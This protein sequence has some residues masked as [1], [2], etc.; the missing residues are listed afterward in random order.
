MKRGGKIKQTTSDRVF[1]V[2]GWTY[3]FSRIATILL[4]VGLITHYFFYSVMIVRGRSME[5][6]YVDGHVLMINKIAYQLG[7]PA[8]GDVIAMYFPGETEKRFVK[9]VIALPGETVAV[10]N[11]KTTVNGEPLDEAYLPEDLETVPDL[12]RTLQSG[13]FF[14]MGD[15][16]P[17]SSDSRAWGAVPSSFIIGKVG[18][19]LFKLGESTTP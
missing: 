7:S 5:P 11:G 3:D 18:S 2:A 19:P 10:T 1:W 14:V 4:L 13:E 12:N 9:R 17:F 16:R 8:R 6:N 15:N